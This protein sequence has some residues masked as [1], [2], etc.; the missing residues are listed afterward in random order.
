LA[1]GA[2][3]R[4]AVGSAAASNFPSAAGDPRGVGKSV[5]FDD[6]PDCRSYRGEFRW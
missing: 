1:C 4:S 3:F 5:V 6:A 2:A